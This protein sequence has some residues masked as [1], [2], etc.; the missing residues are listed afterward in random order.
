MTTCCFPICSH[1]ATTANRAAQPTCATHRAVVV[2]GS[3]V[4][5]KHAEGGHG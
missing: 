4:D 1:P 5:D 3:Y 2:S